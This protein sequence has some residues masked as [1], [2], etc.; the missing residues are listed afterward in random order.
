MKTIKV[1][2]NDW[3]L[4]AKRKIKLKVKTMGEVITKYHKLIRYLKLN[5]ELE[6]LDTKE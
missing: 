4:L 6:S 5:E 1:E 3:E 2:E